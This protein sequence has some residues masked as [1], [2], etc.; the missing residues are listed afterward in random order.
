MGFIN[1]MKLKAL[2][3]VEF[4]HTILRELITSSAVANNSP[5]D[6]MTIKS[7]LDTLSD[8]ALFEKYAK[9][10]T[11]IAQ[12][13]AYLEDTSKSKIAPIKWVPHERALICVDNSRIART[14]G[15]HT[16]FEL[17]I[18]TSNDV[19]LSYKI[20]NELTMN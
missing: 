8:E 15:F 2:E 3:I 17:L 10:L 18:R 6:F 7:Y 19:W 11:S 16:P 1:R 20:P 4:N 13:D 9:C 5:S 12:A 14:L